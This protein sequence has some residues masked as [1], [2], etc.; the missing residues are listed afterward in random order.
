MGFILTES[1]SSMSFNVVVGRGIFVGVKSEV[2]SQGRIWTSFHW[3]YWGLGC[4]L[5]QPVDRIDS[6]LSGNWVLEMKRGFM[7][8]RR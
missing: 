6:S 7:R 2:R 3:L 5:H 1:T 4:T 8:S